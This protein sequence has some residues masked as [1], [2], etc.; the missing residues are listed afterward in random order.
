V[1]TNTGKEGAPTVTGFGIDMIL[2]KEMEA[3]E[4]LREALYFLEQIKKLE[5]EGRSHTFSEDE[6][7]K[8]NLV[9]R[10][11][12]SAFVL[13]WHS[14]PEIML[15]DFA[16]KFKLPFTRNDR[17]MYFD[18]AL[19]ALNNPNRDDALDLLAWLAKETKELRK[20]HNRLAGMRDIVTH[21]GIIVTE[22]G[23]KQV[24]ETV[25]AVNT[26][27]VGPYFIS[28]APFQDWYPPT[29][30]GPDEEPQTIGVAAAGVRPVE[31]T[32]VK[33]PYVYGVEKPIVLSEEE[34]KEKIEPFTYLTGDPDKIP[35]SDRCES[36]Y[37]DMKKLVDE[38]W[39]R[40]NVSI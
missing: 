31:D 26:S 32:S 3:R 7:R 19:A 18:F 11:N 12:L 38:A 16:E 20:K 24:V 1:P 40:T 28:L 39:T 23:E 25:E 14:I 21:R 17:M 33:E 37:N 30:D 13:A 34:K 22:R 35:I 8:R 6:F 4:K 10:A 5:D 36:A 2:R 9:L 27:G 15:Y 29:Q